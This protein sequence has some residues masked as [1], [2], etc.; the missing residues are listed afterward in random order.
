MFSFGRSMGVIEGV[1]A[2]LELPVRWVLPVRWKRSAGILNAEKGAALTL[3][4]EA[5]PEL[6]AWPNNKKAQL[7][8][9]DA[10][11]IAE[12]GE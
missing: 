10:V 5:H 11:L 2:A 8:I 6:I 9:A 7:G 4:K 3:V 1:C 12:N